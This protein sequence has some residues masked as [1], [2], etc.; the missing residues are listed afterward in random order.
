MVISKRNLCAASVTVGIVALLSGSADIALAAGDFEAGLNAYKARDFKGAVTAFQKCTQS[1]QNSASLWLYLGHSYFGAGDSAHALQA[2]RYLADRYPKTAE[3]QVAIQYLGKLDPRA[4]AKYQNAAVAAPTA[5]PA[6]GAAPAA[7][8]GKAVGLI[9][10]IVIIPPRNGHPPVSQQMISTVQEICRQIPRNMYQLLSKGGATI[11]LGPN[12]DDKWPGS[13]EQIKPNEADTTL[14]EEPGRTYGH[15]VHIY[16]RKKARGDNSL[17]DAR[18]QS[19]I[20]RITYHELG[21][22]IDDI[23]GPSPGTALSGTPAF[24]NLLQLDLS[25]VSDADRSHYSYYTE[26]GEACAESVAA[27][28]GSPSPSPIVAEYPKLRQFLKEK[29]KL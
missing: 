22:A 4:A 15:D 14:G 29:L 1:G 16:E 28:M 19:E 17:L 24:R 3:A 23:S 10:R 11:N 21:H 26:P 20:S 8:A 2:Y 13:G 5:S 9:D 25:N 12:I 6:G 7:A 27:L 18:P